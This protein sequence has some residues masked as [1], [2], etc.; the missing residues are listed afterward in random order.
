[1]KNNLIIYCL[2]SLITGFFLGK[3]YESQDVEISGNISASSFLNPAILTIKFNDSNVI[4]SKLIDN[5]TYNGNYK[6]NLVVVKCAKNMNKYSCLVEFDG[7]T[8]Q[9]QF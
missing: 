6:G 3:N 4:Q 1:M 2:V 8:Q 7:T 5:S 9:L